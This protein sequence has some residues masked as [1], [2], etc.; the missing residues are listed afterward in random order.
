MF[1]RK[2]AREFN[3]LEFILLIVVWF[4]LALSYAVWKN[5]MMAVSIFFLH[6]NIRNSSALSCNTQ[7]C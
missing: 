5:Y 4:V 2:N 6:R 7:A 3:P 1:M